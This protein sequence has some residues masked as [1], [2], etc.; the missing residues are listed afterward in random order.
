MTAPTPRRAARRRRTALVVGGDRGGDLR[1]LHPARRA[2]ADERRQPARGTRQ[3]G[4]RGG[5]RVRVHLLAGAAVPHRLREG[6]RHPPGATAPREAVAGQAPAAKRAHGHRAVRRRR[7]LQAAV[8]LPPAT[9]STMQVRPGRAVRDHV[10]RPQHQRPRHRRQRGAVGRAGARLGLLQQDRML[11]L[12]RADARRPARARD[13]PV[14]FIVDPALPADV[15]TITLSYTFFKNDALTAQLQR[16]A[17][18]RR[19]APRRGTVILQHTHQTHGTTAMAQAH[20]A[21]TPTLYY[22]PHGSRW[23]FVRLDRAV[24]HHVRPRQLAQRGELGQVGVLRRPRAC[25]PRSCSSGSAT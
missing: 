14:R 23:P 5:W 19:R 1:R 24:H 2:S 8:G 3:A 6:V 10:L 22:V 11:L 17:Q 15:N 13:M 21:T 20:A 16:A 25:L 4:R 7:Q 12:H 9:R 18:R